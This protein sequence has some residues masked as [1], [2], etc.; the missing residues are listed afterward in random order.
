MSRRPPSQVSPSHAAPPEAQQ[1]GNMPPGW[2]AGDHLFVDDIK[3]SFGATKVLHGITMHLRRTETAVIIG[4]SGAGKTTLL[5]LLI[6]LERPTT[7]HIW[8]DGV[9]MGALGD[10]EM[11]RMR[12]RFG[13][14][15]QYAA[16]L[17]SLTIF[18]NVAFP[19]REHRKHMSKR[20]I[21]DKVVGMLNSLGL[22]N[23]EDRMP[24]ELSGGQRKRVG[25]ARALMLE[26][27]ILIYDEPTSGLDPLT[28]RLV[29]DLIE[30]TRARFKV[31]SVVISHD[32]AS[33]FRI[34]H[35]AFLVIQGRVVASGT[36]D[37]LAH[38]D[39]EQARQFIAA[40]GVATDEVSRVNRPAL[41]D[42][43]G[44]RVIEFRKA[45]E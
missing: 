29:D 40:S 37:E 4:G 34:A 8:V 11:N 25:L 6:G 22:E 20:D 43:T 24:S 21:R 33:T 14:V 2:Q 36:P 7:G 31:T 39:N 3:K 1:V 32:M 13:M 44:G 30:E 15:F 23:K 9:D 17:D 26:P 38:G 16:L 42:G 19:L 28:S 41:A 10:F 5:R 18:D 27:E 35:Q 12:Q 45:A